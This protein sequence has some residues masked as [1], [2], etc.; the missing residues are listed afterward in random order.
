MKEAPG[1]QLLQQM[2]AHSVDGV[3][4]FDRECRFTYWSPAMER[5]S[6]MKGADVVGQLA[7]QLFPY[8]L[9]IGEDQCLPWLLERN[10]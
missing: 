9:A 2:L 3:L 8:L 5:M 6:G 7:F 10:R 1:P 4:A